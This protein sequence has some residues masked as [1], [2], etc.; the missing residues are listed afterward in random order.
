VRRAIGDYRKTFAAIIGLL[1]LALVVGGYIVRKQGLKL[2][3]IDPAPMTLEAEFRQAEGVVAGQGQTVRIAGVRVGEISDV[4]L[5][6]GLAVVEM[7]VES[8]Y[9]DL[10]HEDAT[11][12]LRPRSGL[13]DMFVEL[14]PGAKS[15]PLAGDGFRIPVARTQPD[16]SFDELLGVLDGDT[17]DHLRLLVSDLG[18]GLEGRAPQL[19][20]ILRRFE[21]THRD[22]AAV[23]GALARRRGNLRRLVHSLRLVSGELAGRRVELAQ[24]VDASAAALGATASRRPELSASIAELPG[25]LREA[26]LALDRIERFAAELGPAAERLVP[27]ARELEPVS[28][29]LRPLALDA[30][31]VLR[32][33]LRPAVRA[34]RDPVRSL[35]P[36]SARLAAAAPDLTR[37][38]RVLNRFFNMLGHNPGGREEPSVQGRNEGFLFWIAWATHHA[39]NAWSLTDAHGP[40]HN[41]LIT[42][43]CTAI[44]GLVE[45]DP[46]REFLQNLTPILTDPRFCGR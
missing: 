20:E 8:E 7:D 17:R 5:E 43:S 14:S 35:R 12:L 42:A 21:P 29:E 4:R 27:A 2:P 16:V 36:A 10:V 33:G 26:T 1:V 30:V 45:A 11:A 39:L 25:T 28:A 24:L 34:A 38:F 37:D 3:L 18:S 41:T 31:P 46:V 15:A 44:R 19:R 6:D 13:K 23:A 40:L 32:H 22:L 9:A